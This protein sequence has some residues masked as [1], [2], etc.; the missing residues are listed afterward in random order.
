MVTPATVFDYHVDAAELETRK[1][2]QLPSGYD[3]SEYVTERVLAAARDGVQVPVSVVRRREN[4][5]GRHGPAVSLRLWRIRHCYAACL[6]NYP[7][8]AAG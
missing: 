2:Q 8:V 7:A 1:V 5:G 3:A 4:P 6:L